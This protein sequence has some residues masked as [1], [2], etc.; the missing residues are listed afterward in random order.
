VTAGFL[1][2]WR[3]LLLGSHF[4]AGCA[5][6]AVTV[7]SGSGPLTDKAAEVFRTW[8][9]TLVELMRSSGASE[10]DATRHATRL[11]ASAEGAVVLCRAERTIE[12]FDI[13]A[14]D[15]L[16]QARSIAV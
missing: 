16:R 5:V 10:D 9:A 12:P 14:D 6:L 13:V 3:R 7:A 8:R 11:L 2:L 15:L 1:E 4:R